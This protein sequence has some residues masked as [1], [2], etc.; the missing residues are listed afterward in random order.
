MRPALLSP[1]TRK[2]SEAEYHRKIHNILEKTESKYIFSDTLS[3]DQNYKG[4]KLLTSDMSYDQ[5][6]PLL[7]R[8]KI[9]FAQLSSG[10]TGLQKAALISH[11]ALIK[12]MKN[13]GDAIA[14]T[15]RDRFISWLPLYH[16]MG[17]IACFL[18]PLMRG[19]PFM[20]MD[21]FDWLAK[22]QLLFDAVATYR[23][24]L[25][26][27]PN[28]AF[29]VLANKC[30][31]VDFSSMRMFINCSE[32]AR[33]STLQLF[34]QKFPELK[35]ENLAVCYALAE[36]TFAVSQ[37]PVFQV[38]VAKKINGKSVLSCGKIIPG[39]QLKILNANDDGIGEV[40]ICGDTLFS[41][42]L[43]SNIEKI[44]GY[45]PTGDLG[46][47]SNDELFITGRIKDL[48]IIHGKNFYPQDIEH[49]VSEVKG[50]YPGRVV[51]FG[52]ENNNAGTEQLVILV[53]I[54]ANADSGKV[55]RD[56][57]QNIFNEFEIIPIAEILPYMTL[58][59]TSSGKVSRTRNRE[60]YLSRNK[61]C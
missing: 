34:L 57:H 42:F 46:F 20:V 43:N 32:P 1:K 12:H 3:N 15:K 27:L 37:T 18:L 39:T 26:Y 45:Y 53:E 59:K 48:I 31:S 10:S 21:P 16:D 11:D 28:F 47:I 17:L 2:I 56:I 19:I 38:P 61:K 52:I 41:Q 7:R 50:V 5:I 9:A 51:S 36:N 4:I 22:P 30:Q 8:E 13:Y 23:C 44:D 14:L 25:C 54:E 60:L 49:C 6:K 58:I 55:L 29:H 40:A 35:K 33:A 24:S